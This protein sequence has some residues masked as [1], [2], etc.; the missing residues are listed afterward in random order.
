MAK[1]KDFKKLKDQWL[2]DA[3]IR[4]IRKNLE[5]LLSVD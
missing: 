5:G 2:K 1:L 4:I 3:E